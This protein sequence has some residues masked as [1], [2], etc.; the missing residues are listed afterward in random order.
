[1][2]IIIIIVVL[3]IIQEKYTL[4]LFLTQIHEIFVLSWPEFPKKSEQRL[5]EHFQTLPKIKMSLF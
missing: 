5:S 3:K 1:M 4:Q 2:I